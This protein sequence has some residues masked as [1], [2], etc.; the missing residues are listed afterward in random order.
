MKKRLFIVILSLTLL[1]ISCS[2]KAKENDS[3]IK[4][5]DHLDRVVEFDKKAERIVTGYFIASSMVIALDLKDNMV[6]I[7]FNADRQKVYNLIDKKLFTLPSVGSSKGIDL[8]KLASLKP[9]LYIVPTRLKSEMKALEDIG[10][11]V[12]AINPENESLW[13]ESIMMIAK[14]TGKEEKAEK[15]FKFYDEK[16]NMLNKKIKGEKKKIYFAGNR[17]FLTTATTKMYQTSLINIAGGENV[18]KDLTDNYWANI[19]NE[20]LL[21]YDPEII[22]IPPAASY[23][24]EDIVNNKEYSSLRAIKEGKIYAMPDDYGYWDAPISTTIM[25]SLWIA[26]T[27][28]PEIYSEKEFNKDLKECYKLY[29]NIDIKDE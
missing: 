2:P 5:K 26:K 28:N 17:D 14:A 12:L 27:I 13:K 9:D 16:I 8:E 21:S 19:S 11:N 6:G 7:E 22:I 20:Q 1:L 4:V 23:S 29:Y 10:I 25:G 24:K 15:L 3:K 18:A